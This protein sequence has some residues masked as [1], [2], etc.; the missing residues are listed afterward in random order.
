MLFSLCEL[1][2]CIN[3]FG[4][5]V[6]HIRIKWEHK[7]ITKIFWKGYIWLFQNNCRGF[8]N[9]SYTIHLR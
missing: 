6:V 1:S 8:N 4:S 3:S 7:Y 2:F 9:L 5:M